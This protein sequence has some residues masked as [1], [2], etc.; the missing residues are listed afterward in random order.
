VVA[1]HAGVLI[2]EPLLRSIQQALNSFDESLNNPNF[3]L[4]QNQEQS[5]N[6]GFSENFGETF[7]SKDEKEVE[8]NAEFYKE[9]D[10][11]IENQYTLRY[12][13]K[14]FDEWDNDHDPGYVSVRMTEDEFIASGDA[15]FDQNKIEKR[16][17][18]E[19]SAEEL[20]LENEPNNMSESK[21]NKA[22]PSPSHK[23]PKPDRKSPVENL[24][25][26]IENSSKGPRSSSVGLSPSILLSNCSSSPSSIDDRQLSGSSSPKSSMV[27]N[28]RREYSESSQA[29]SMCSSPLKGTFTPKNF[30]PLVPR[31]RPKRFNNQG[32]EKREF[33]VNKGTAALE[34][35]D[36]NNDDLFQLS[37][38]GS[39]NKNDDLSLSSEE[40]SLLGNRMF[41]T[42]SVQNKID[43]SETV[44][45]L[46]PDN[47]RSAA[48]TLKNDSREENHIQNSLS[49]RNL[50]EE[51]EMML[52][53]ADES[54]E[55]T[56]QDNSILQNGTQEQNLNGDEASEMIH[57]YPSPEKLDCLPLRVVFEK[58]RTGLQ[59]SK[60]FFYPTGSV[61]AGRY[62]VCREIG[63]TTFS[64]A[65]HCA[66]HL[67]GAHPVCLKI[68]R[69]NKDYFDK[70]LDEIKL[71]RYMNT[72]GHPEKY[73]I[74]SMMDYFYFQEHLII[75]SE[76]LGENLHELSVRLK[77]D[78]IPNYFTVPRVK[79]IMKQV[80]EA[81]A[82]MNR[83]GLI[84]CDI[85]P[86]NI[87]MK[88]YLRGHVKLIDFGSANFS[89]NFS[90]VYVQS[91]A[92]RA[93]EVI[94]GLPHLS[95]GID[96]WSLGAVMGEL[97]TGYVLFEN[98]SCTSL[99]ARITSITG[100][101]PSY[102]IESGTLSWKYYT[103][104]GVLFRRGQERNDVE[105]L[106]PK[107]TSLQARF[108]QTDPILLDFATCMLSNDPRDRLFPCE[109]L[110][111]PWMTSCE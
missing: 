43:G 11:K 32:E 2:P 25:V 51:E 6:E 9:N 70:S 61:V 16:E 63:S 14:V 110:S 18:C 62:Q 44:T 5:T 4:P 106:Y 28:N 84:H 99:L 69:N 67:N 57:T 65:M 3:S 38:D 15:I 105:L 49:Q 74:L 13:E 107:Q 79:L 68:V 86:E 58:G 59:C 42:S 66:D 109:A 21:L 76:L 7:A 92:Y 55:T 26:R 53:R 39:E 48:E 36:F 40:E 83:I 96:S 10:D 60:D 104:E 50:V 20:K 85:K 47:S 64:T 72:H 111:H 95:P 1:Y 34:E 22:S 35:P 33:V 94:L 101:L 77:Q 90:A 103:S 24:T 93:P 41:M 88:D 73:N 82:F 98:D 52:S 97:L 29:S 31:L 81:L 45:T 56:L 37:Q 71:L 27:N 91:R 23:T 54:M 75:V 78:D 17:N 87:A 30:G 80:L 89:S 102:M 19:E 12:T 108:D 8:E 100:P 46:L